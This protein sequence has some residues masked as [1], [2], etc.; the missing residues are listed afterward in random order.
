MKALDTRQKQYVNKE[1]FMLFMRD[2]SMQ[3][4]KQKL[5]KSFSSFS[6][7]AEKLRKELERKDEKMKFLLDAQSQNCEF[8]NSI[9]AKIGATQ[10]NQL[11]IPSPFDQFDLES[12]SKRLKKLTEKTEEQCEEPAQF[13]AYMRG[14]RSKTRV[15]IKRGNT[16]AFGASGELRE[17]ELMV[18]EVIEGSGSYEEE[19]NEEEEEEENGES[20]QGNN[21]NVE[22]AEE[23]D[24]SSHIEGEGE[25][26]GEE[27][28]K[29]VECVSNH[30][31]D[32]VGDI[33]NVES[34]D[35]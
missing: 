27:E 18:E 28:E 17:G 30:D 34:Q 22:E 13:K 5:L 8:V 9:A 32:H 15:N 1:E 2:E 19:E 33:G 35:Q 20:E 21:D 12:L 31:I 26:E 7:K 29:K 16:P 3:Q 6:K 4:E 25:G 24:N 23:E 10:P 11:Q 14:E